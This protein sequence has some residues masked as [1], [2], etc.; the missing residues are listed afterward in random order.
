MRYI[1]GQVASSHTCSMSG[2]FCRTDL[3]F[4]RNVGL[5]EIAGLL[6]RS[7]INGR[8]TMAMDMNPRVLDAHP[9]PSDCN[10]LGAAKGN[11]PPN[12]LR[13]NVLPANTLATYRG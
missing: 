1:G 2:A 10:I 11:A 5:Q 12:E 9:M 13:K 6:T 8:G 4:I 7:K 3:S